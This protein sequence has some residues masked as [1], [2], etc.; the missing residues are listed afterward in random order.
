MR[1]DSGGDSDSIE[2]ELT[3]SQDTLFMEE[4]YG[5]AES[6]GFSSG[7]ASE[8]VS[9]FSDDSVPAAQTEG[10]AVVYLDPNSGDDAKD[11]KSGTTAIKNLRNALTMAQGGTIYLLNPINIDE[12]VTLENVTLRPGTANL[13]YMLTMQLSICQ[14]VQ[15]V[16][17]W[18]QTEVEYML[19]TMQLSICRVV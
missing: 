14:A 5:D 2:K 4:N 7:N 13:T 15:F 9:E 3:E 10:N 19:Q 1:R 18:Q 8:S 6:V 16:N 17:R 11:G 12:D